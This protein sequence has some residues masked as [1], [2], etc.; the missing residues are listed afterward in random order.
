MKKMSRAYI[1]LMFLSLCFHGVQENKLNSLLGK[2]QLLKEELEDGRL[3]EEGSIDG[4]Y[5]K[6]ELTFFFDKSRVD[7]ESNG[8]KTEGLKYVIK[9]ENDSINMLVISYKKYFI[10]K[11]TDTEMVLLEDRLFAS[12]LFFKKAQSTE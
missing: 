2:W 6:T 8:V 7:V 10:E 11:L 1:F 4:K 9:R 12:R 3:M 5:K